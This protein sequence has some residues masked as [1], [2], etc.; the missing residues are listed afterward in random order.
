MGLEPRVVGIGQRIGGVE[1]AAGRVRVQQEGAEL[2]A[3]PQAAV[4]GALDR[5]DVEV[6]ARDRARLVVLAY[7][8]GLARP[9]WR[10]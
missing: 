2:I 9:G 5:L 10:E 4:A 6:G 7:Q 8:S 3:D 1:H